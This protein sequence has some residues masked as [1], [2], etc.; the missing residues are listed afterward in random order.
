VKRP[1]KGAKRK[2]SFC[3]SQPLW[4]G[5]RPVLETRWT[6]LA[7]LALSALS[8]S[9]ISGCVGTEVARTGTFGKDALE[10]G[11]G[12]ERKRKGRTVAHPVLVCWHQLS[13]RESRIGLG[14]SPWGA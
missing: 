13:D 11:S 10:E 5:W 9:G 2:L 1:L 6:S 3:R 12:K 7:Y 14:I 8:P 4:V